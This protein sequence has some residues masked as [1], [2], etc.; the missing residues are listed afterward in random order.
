MRS[1]W[2]ARDQE[3]GGKMNER[4]FAALVVL[5]GSFG[6]IVG[7]LATWGTC[8]NL[9]CGSGGLMSL[10]ERSGVSW[11]PGILTLILGVLLVAIAVDALRGGMSA[12]G[13]RVAL[14]ASVGVLGVTLA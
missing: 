3:E 6:V 5:L 4:R 8:P 10:W 14:G 12:M 1:T 11:G 2:D 7:S 9:S 13:W